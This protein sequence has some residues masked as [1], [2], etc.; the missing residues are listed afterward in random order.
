MTVEAMNNAR[1]SWNRSLL[2]TLC[3]QARLWNYEECKG[4]SALFRQAKGT[5]ANNVFLNL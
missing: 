2:A 4:L 3:P 1:K 5:F